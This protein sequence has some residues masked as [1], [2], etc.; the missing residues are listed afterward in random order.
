MSE[1]FTYGSVGGA[2]GN[3]GPYPEKGW[4]NGGDV[5][6]ENQEVSVRRK[7]GAC[8]LENT[9]QASVK[10]RTRVSPCQIA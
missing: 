7:R 4:K 9:C 5:H 10:S 3:L 6:G 2:E 8:F 1:W